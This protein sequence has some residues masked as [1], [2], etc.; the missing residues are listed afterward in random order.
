MLR[1]LT[2]LLGA[3]AERAL[4]DLLLGVIAAAA[5]AL[6]AGISL[7]FGTFAAYVHLSVT[8]GPVVAAMIVGAVY[9]LLAIMTCAFVMV[10]RRRRLR[11]AVASAS[12]VPPGNVESLLQS[13]AGAGAP[14]DQQAMAA[15][16]QLGRELSPIQLLALALIG[17]FITGR[18][19]GK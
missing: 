6:L 18:T 4:A 7:A 1:W 15:A 19:L 8:E 11:V 14:L 2:G 16:L 3:V 17:G 10:R 12:A 13:L 9:G 5:V